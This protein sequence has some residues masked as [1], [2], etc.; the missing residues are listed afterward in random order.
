M[1]RQFGNGLLF[2]L[3]W[4]TENLH[5]SAY[6]DGRGFNMQKLEEEK[7]GMGLRGIESRVKS[8]YGEFKI[9]SAEGKGTT[10]MID[11]PI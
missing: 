11:L 10:I 7:S 4:T 9:D 3:L 6:D 5:I 2:L 1:E 8:L